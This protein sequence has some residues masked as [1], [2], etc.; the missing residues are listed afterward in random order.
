[1]T[2]DCPGVP[3]ACKR[4]DCPPC[5]NAR[6]AYDALRAAWV[7]AYAKSQTLVSDAADHAEHEAW[8]ALI[9]YVEAEDL[10]GTNLD[11]RTQLGQ[12]E[13]T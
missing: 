5:H 8:N 4:R 6:P 9:D 13:Q 7:A 12:E 2:A 3:Q 1:M 11:P 10:N